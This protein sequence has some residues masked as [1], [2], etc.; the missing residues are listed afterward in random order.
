MSDRALKSDPKEAW[1]F[2]AAMALW[3]LEMLLIGIC[4]GLCIFP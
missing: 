2:W 4:I 1:Y 3:G